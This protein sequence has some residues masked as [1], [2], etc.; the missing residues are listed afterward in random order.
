MKYCTKCGYE[1]EDRDNFCRNCG[2][3]INENNKSDESILNGSNPNNNMYYQN[4]Y[5]QQPPTN[6]MAIAGIILAFFVPILGLIFGIIGLN[7]SN[8]PEYRGEGKGLAIAAI[9]ISAISL[10]ISLICSVYIIQL[11]SNLFEII[12]SVD[13]IL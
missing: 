7:K 11:Y 5:Y 1:N 9:V 12:N 2:N 13:Y 3:P 4:N 6:G 8:T 10:I